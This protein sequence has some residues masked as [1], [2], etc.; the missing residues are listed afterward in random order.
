MGS[1]VDCNDNSMIESFWSRMEVE[2]LDRKKLKTRIELA[3]A[4]FDY[5]RS[6]T[7]F[8]DATPIG[9]L[10]SVVSKAPTPSPWD[11][12]PDPRLRRTRADQSPDTQ[13]RFPTPQLA[14][15]GGAHIC[16]R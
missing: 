10:P 5:P 6:G 4:I 8:G 12:N 7:T 2:L 15:D 13:G 3:K 11:E 9:W 14:G 1:V 16:A